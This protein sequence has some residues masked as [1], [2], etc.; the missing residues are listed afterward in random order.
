M[1]IS[2]SNPTYPDLVVESPSVSDTTLTPSQSFTASAT[3]KNKGNATS[4]STT[5]RYYRSTDSTITTGDTQISTDSVVSLSPGGTS[6]E[7][8]AV[9]APTTTGTYWIGACVD[10]VNGES[11]TGNNCSTGVQI[12]IL[13][14][15][16]W[17]MFLPAITNVGDNTGN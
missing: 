2:V 9:S 10:S 11:S 12:N 8:A 13:S 16:P 6:V 15:F 1:Q 5:L 17:T 7:S 14:D 4:S 3:V